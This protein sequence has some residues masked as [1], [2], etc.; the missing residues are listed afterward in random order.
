VRIEPGRGTDVVALGQRRE[1][2]AAAL[3]PPGSVHGARAFHHAPPMVVVDYD[4][5]GVVELIEVPLADEPE[6]QVVLDGVRLTG[7]ALD[8]VRADLE[9]LGHHGRD[10]DIGVD[11]P[12]GFAIWSMGSRML[13]DVD[14]SAAAD[15]ERPVVEGVSVASPAYFGF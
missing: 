12:A 11:Y 10:S 3:G 13:S 14:P 2:V 4:D 15:D 9:A 8:E 1:E 7:R 6:H 5:A